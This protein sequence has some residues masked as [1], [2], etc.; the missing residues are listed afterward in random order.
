MNRQQILS[1]L[2]ASFGHSKYPTLHDVLTFLHTVPDSALPTSI[3][4]CGYEGEISL[5]WDNG[6]AFLDVGFDGGGTYEYEG[7]VGTLFISET[8][9]DPQRLPSNIQEFLARFARCK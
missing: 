7:H 3:V 9:C 1:L 6:F 8:G 2:H 4:L 5:F